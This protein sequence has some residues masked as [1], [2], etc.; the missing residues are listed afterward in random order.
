MQTEEGIARQS[1]PSP[2]QSVIT[3]RRHTRLGR[4][5]FIVATMVGL[6][7]LMLVLIEG[8]SSG[9][10][11]AR[12]V[13]LALAAAPDSSQQHLQYDPLVGWLWRPNLHVPHLWGPGVYFRTNAQGFR[14][15][16]ATTRRA[17][18][19][20]LRIVCSGDS[21]TEGSGVDNEHTWCELLAAKDVRFEG[22][23]MGQGGYGLDQAYL[24][25]KRDGQRFDHAVNVL[26]F[27]TDDFRR[28]A[29]SRDWYRHKPKLVVRDG[30][31]TT[32]NVPVPQGLLHR[33]WQYVVDT[34]QGLRTAHFFVRLKAKIGATAITSDSALADVVTAIINDLGAMG[35][36][37]DRLMLLLYLPTL[38]D[39]LSRSADPWRELVRAA[40]ADA[41]NVAYVDLISALKRLPPDTVASFFISYQGQDYDRRGD[42]HLT[43]RGNQWVAD[44]VY[45]YLRGRPEIG[46]SPPESK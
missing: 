34:I 18:P 37:H 22:I 25:Y 27:I 31:L 45:E 17:A 11:F 3:G 41:P 28:A 46:I 36:A 32:E 44:N 10:L 9:I 5:V 24:R 4:A 21:F 8:M 35:Q 42:G 2:H 16:A 30:V 29:S 14:S 39:Y 6:T 12:D 43:V 7:A 1:A 23:N 26:A 38:D 13:Y 33:R 40:A 19:G 15:N 20:R